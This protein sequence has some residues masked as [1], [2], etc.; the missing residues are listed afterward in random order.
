MRLREEQENILPNLRRLQVHRQ[1]LHV[2]RAQGQGIAFYHF[3]SFFNVAWL[4]RFDF[5]GIPA[6]VLVRI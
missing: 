1:A 3:P 4:R 2:A 5:T 6:A